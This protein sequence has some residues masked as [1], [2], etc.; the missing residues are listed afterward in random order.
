MTRVNH[1]PTVI[2]VWVIG[3]NPV[4]IPEHETVH[5]RVVI[6][7]GRI[8]ATCWT[9][10]IVT[11]LGFRIMR[12]FGFM[13]GLGL[14]SRL[15]AISVD[16]GLFFFGRIGGDIGFAFLDRLIGFDGPFLVIVTAPRQQQQKQSASSPL[17]DRSCLHCHSHR[18]RP[19]MRERYA[20]CFGRCDIPCHID[21]S[22][23]LHHLT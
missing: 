1:T 12:G 6:T 9:I 17:K 8:S 19:A 13:I 7:T 4:E 21:S 16:F 10:K 2:V 14:I 23:W 15:L 20:F 22:R 5:V 11:G 3:H 18:S